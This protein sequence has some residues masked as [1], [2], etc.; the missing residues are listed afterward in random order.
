MS[1]KKELLKL[2][3]KTLLNKVQG[4]PQ[5]RGLVLDPVAHRWKKPNTGQDTGQ[6]S[7]KSNQYGKS[8]LPVFSDANFNPKS[9]QWVNRKAYNS[10]VGYKTPLADQPSSMFN[11]QYSPHDLHSDIQAMDDES[12]NRMAKLSSD[13]VLGRQNDLTESMLKDDGEIN[14][15]D[16]DY[17]R[18]VLGNEGR[19]RRKIRGDKPS[20]Y[21]YGP[22]TGKVGQWD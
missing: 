18:H 9:N 22:G 20:G 5:Q 19:R 15:A 10:K 6:Q 21:M 16:L 1:K 11:T 13:A 12:L 14:E 2:Y 3:Y 4:T 17:V 7:G 8:D